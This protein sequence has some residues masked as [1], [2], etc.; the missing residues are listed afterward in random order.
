[1]LL[2]PPEGVVL[3]RIW[4]GPGPTPV[5]NGGANE[6]S[7]QRPRTVMLA[8][9]TGPA[10]G[11]NGHGGS[12]RC[13]GTCL[14]PGGRSR[15]VASA[16]DP[17]S[18]AGRR[19]AGYLEPNVAEAQR[20]LWDAVAPLRLAA[21]DGQRRL[22]QE[23]KALSATS[24]KERSWRPSW[25]IACGVSTLSSRSQGGLRWTC[26]PARCCSTS[27]GHADDRAEAQAARASYEAAAKRY[28]QDGVSAAPLQLVCYADAACCGRTS[29]ATRTG[30]AAVRQGAGPDDVP[31]LFAAAT[32]VDYGVAAA[33]AG[34]YED[35]LFLRAGALLDECGATKRS[36]SLGGPRLRR[37]PL[38]PDDQWKVDEAA[39]RFQEAY[40][41]RL[42]NKRRRIRSHPSTSSTT[43]W[44]AIA[45]R[46]RGNP[47]AAAPRLQDAGRR[48]GPG[49]RQRPAGR[50]QFGARSGR[51][52]SERPGSKPICGTQGRWA[53]SMERWADCELYAG[54]AASA[55]PGQ[56]GPASA[57]P[58]RESRSLNRD[59]DLG[60]SV[61]MTCKLCLVAALH[62][63][64][65][66]A[67]P[68]G[69]AAGGRDRICW[70]GSGTAALLRQVPR[71][72]C[73]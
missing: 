55:S 57:R 45:Q 18:R 32:R 6:N 22:I 49:R 58:V 3:S 42:A 40:S 62:G 39:K 43:E 36:I 71:R 11:L 53:N 29:C 59:L 72:S 34:Q 23:L 54:C 46:Y 63:K 56:S 21:G 27:G 70:T 47:D 2:L 73:V 67:Q 26:T 8:V 12:R 50:I 15:A 28:A 5:V 37:T 65:P 4:Q 19:S 24:L 44:T 61:V 9:E 69:R 33:S 14:A 66:N 41:I 60:T 30:E 20:W 16:G 1:V 25:R 17:G 10:A 52:A 64:S 13:P 35:H 7:R 48:S 68:G 31:E 51:V 38:E